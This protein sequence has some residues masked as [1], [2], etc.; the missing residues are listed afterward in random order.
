LN[1][2]HKFLT[3]LV[4]D[5]LRGDVVGYYASTSNNEIRFVDGLYAEVIDGTGRNDLLRDLN[6]PPVNP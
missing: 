3:E 2:L 4:L 1:G 5:G 6:F